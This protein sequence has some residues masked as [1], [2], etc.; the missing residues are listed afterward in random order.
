VRPASD[1]TLWEWRRKRGQRVPSPFVTLP[2]RAYLTDARETGGGR[3][4]VAMMR[5][6]KRDLSALRAFS[7]SFSW[8]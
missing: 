3:G 8:A 6:E 2:T 1:V 5:E 7:T 4:G